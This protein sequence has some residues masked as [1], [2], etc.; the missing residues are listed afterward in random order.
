MYIDIIRHI[1]SLYRRLLAQASDRS[2]ACW[3]SRLR[4][5][6]LNGEQ[7]QGWQPRR[8]LRAI[9]VVVTEDEAAKFDECDALTL[10]D[11]DDKRM[12][13]ACVVSDMQAALQTAL[14]VKTKAA[15]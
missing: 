7:Y 11:F 12:Q 5:V 9:F 2:S 8:L 10:L 3:S 1:D 14:R 13:Y 4:S 6:H 15:V